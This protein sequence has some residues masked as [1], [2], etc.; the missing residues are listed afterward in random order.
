VDRPTQTIPGDDP[1]IDVTVT[2]SPMPL[3]TSPEQPRR[4]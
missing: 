4:R 3:T 1:H 2:T